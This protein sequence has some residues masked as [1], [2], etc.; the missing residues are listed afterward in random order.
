MLKKK[1]DFV[2]CFKTLSKVSN[3]IE[4]TKKSR[5]HIVPVDSSWYSMLF[6]LSRKWI[7]KTRE[8]GETWALNRCFDIIIVP[9]LLKQ[10]MPFVFVFVG[11]E[12]IITM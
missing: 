6:F 4:E 7:R 12:H 3:S 11:T 2:E 10:K 9:G 5:N 1:E 8:I